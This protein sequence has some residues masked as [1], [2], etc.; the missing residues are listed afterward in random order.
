[1]EKPL[2]MI[3]TTHMLLEIYLLIQVAI[4]PVLIEEFQLS[5][6][7]A[8]LIATVPSFVQLLMNIPTGFLTERF[9]PNKLLFISMLI[10][11]LSAL[12][13]SQTNTFWLLVLGVS[14]LKISSPVYHI[15]GLSQISRLAKSN[16]VNRSMG[17][18]NAFGSLGSALGLV[19]SLIHI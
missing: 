19:L 17:F 14:L 2:W 18:H 10:E 16:Q 8:S 6:L 12:L 11:G 5:L 4:I 1:M 15:S 3:C 9:S 7:E 13:V